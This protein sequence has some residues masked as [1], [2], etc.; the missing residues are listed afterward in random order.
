MT[1]S[2]RLDFSHAYWALFLCRI[3]SEET[4]NPSG[5]ILVGMRNLSTL[6]KVMC[7]PN[8]ETISPSDETL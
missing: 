5:E 6:E 7:I 2:L 8:D 4:P 1:K 3:P